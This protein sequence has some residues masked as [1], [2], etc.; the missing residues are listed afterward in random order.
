[1]SKKKGGVC[2]LLGALLLLGSLGLAGYNLWDENRAAAA[3]ANAMAVLDA[4]I[5]PVEPRDLTALTPEEADQALIPDYLLDPGM[6]MPTVEAEGNRYIGYL[7]FPTLELSLPV[8]ESWSY[9]L[10]KLGPCRYSGSAYRDDMVVAAHNYRRHFG[11]LS[12]L[13]VGDPV[14]FTD[15]DGNVFFYAVQEAE[16]LSPTPAAAMLAGDWDLSLF[17][18]TLDGQSRYTVRCARTEE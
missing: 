3:S 8:L 16:Q 10:L 11:R 9:P 14:R 1:M 12:S 4:A 17:T 15:A 2:I 6:D 18:C 7:E 13:T 5:T